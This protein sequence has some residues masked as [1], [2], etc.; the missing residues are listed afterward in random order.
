MAQKIL[1]ND[2]IAIQKN[3]VLMR[4]NKPAYF[5]MCILDLSKILMYD[6]IPITLTINIITKLDHYLLM[7]F[8]A[9]WC[10]G[11]HYCRTSFNKA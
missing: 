3:K 9:P 2:W 7:L 4:F 8:V 10:S 1:D 6:F 11:Y 5:R